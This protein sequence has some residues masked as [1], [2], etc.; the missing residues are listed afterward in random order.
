M[1]LL[2]PVPATI[3][4]PSPENRRDHIYNNK[5]VGRFVSDFEEGNIRQTDRDYISYEVQSQAP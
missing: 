4:R 3:S 1:T 2:A 5:S